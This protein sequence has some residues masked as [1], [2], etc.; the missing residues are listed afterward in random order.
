MPPKKGKT[1]GKKG[2]KTKKVDD[3]KQEREFVFKNI[4]D[5]QEYAQVQKLLGNRRCEVQCFDGLI[6]LAHM[7]GNLR[8]K[9]IFISMG[10]IVLVSIREFENTKCD[11]LYQY[12]VK[13]AK[14]LKSLGEVPSN[15]KVNEVDIVVEQTDENDIGIDFDDSDN[16]EK[17]KFK[18]D[19]EENFNAI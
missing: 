12:N 17:E 7:R 10:D 13:E 19:F 8:K 1:G 5:F 9:K 14:K 16:E 6:R 4:E 11:I 3:E 15:I 18:K 2:K